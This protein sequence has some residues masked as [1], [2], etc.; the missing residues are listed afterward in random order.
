M[1]ILVITDLYPVSETEKN[2]PRT[3]YNFVQYWK[4]KGHELRVIKP[5]FLLNS[6]LRSK[7]FYKTGVYGEVENINYFT[8]FWGDIKRKIRTEFVPDVVVAHMPSGLIVANKLGYPFVAA[9]HVSDIEVLTNPLYSLYFKRELESAYENASK[10]ACRSEVLRK[11]FLK[12]YPQYSD[13]T[14]VCF[15][16]IDSKIIVQKKWG[17]GA[18]VLTCAQLIKRKNVDKVITECSKADVN[19]T[20]VGDGKE[21]DNL[22][23]LADKIGYKNICFTGHLAHQRVLELMR[24]YDIFALPSVNETFGMVY[25]EAMASG[26]ITV[27]TEGDGVDGI[28]KNAYNG[29]FWKDGII[30][31]IIDSDNQDEILKNSYETIQNY[32]DENAGE[33]YLDIISSI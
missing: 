13:K 7:P 19:L 4:Q 27:C 8:P 15:S 25:L 5:N 22:K 30:K 24:D 6:F 9:V 11:R 20:V 17:G 21:L 14:S 1:K 10:I 26:C 16:G 29:Y 18:K 3:I 33:N 12:L 32:T 31:E 23:K 2:T 28:I